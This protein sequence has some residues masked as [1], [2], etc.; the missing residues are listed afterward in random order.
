MAV[1][2]RSQARSALL[3]AALV[4]I[5]EVGPIRTHPNEICQE[6]G[7]S[8]A[9]VN[10]HFGNREG[11]VLEAIALGYERYVEHLAAVAAAAGPGAL[12]RLLAWVEAQVDW[13]AS[14]PGLAAALNFPTVLGGEPT[15]ERA[16]TADRIAEAG[17]RNFDNLLA[18][19]VEARREALGVEPDPVDTGLDGSVV[20]WLTLGLSVWISGRHLPTR[21]LRYAEHLPLARAHVRAVV[22]DLVTRPAA[23]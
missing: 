5:S 8:K 16:G 14:N 21:S 23:G 13:T 7:L 4:R 9:L 11:L 3:E 22:T 12:D 20:G 19:V 10:Y 18:L 2:P 6:L 1:V 17:G 15:P